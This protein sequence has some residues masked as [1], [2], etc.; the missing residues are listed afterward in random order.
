MSLVG[1]ERRSSMI[2]EIEVLLVFEVLGAAFR[3]ILEQQPSL[4]EKRGENTNR[5]SIKCVEAVEGARIQRLGE[6][7][8]DI[9][10][11][12]EEFLD[13]DA[14]QRTSGRIC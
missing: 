3:C 14:V 2:A 13:C 8:S 7:S 1:S 5:R 4:L 12:I 6:T 11:W 10:N 9:L